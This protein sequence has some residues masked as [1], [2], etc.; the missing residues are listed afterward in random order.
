MRGLT[1]LVGLSLLLVLTGCGQ[2]PS[3]DSSSNPVAGSRATDPALGVTPGA[4]RTHH[5][6]ASL[7]DRGELAVYEPALTRRDGAYT[8]HRAD[9]S[10]EH[11]LHAIAG[12]HLRVSTPAGEQLDIQFDRAIEHPSGDWTWVGHIAGHDDQQTI[13]TFGQDAAFGTIGQPDGQP[14]RLTVQ[15]RASWIVET[16]PTQFAGYRRASPRGHTDVLMVPPKSGGTAGSQAQGVQ[17]Q[18]SAPVMAAATTATTPTTV[19]LVLGYT[20]GFATA[21]GG[22]SGAITHLNY[23][24][25]VANLA[26]ANSQVPAKVRLVATV[27]VNY[28]DATD[29]DSTLEKLTGFSTASNSQIPTDPAFNGLRAARD[30]YGADMVSLVRSFREPENAGCGLAWLIGGGRRPIDQSDGDFAYSV[31]GDG[32][33]AGTGGHT[34]FC[35]DETLAHELGHGMGAAHDVQTAKGDNG[36][37]DDNEYGAFSYSFGYVNSTPVAGG[38]AGFFTI[39]AYGDN[40]TQKI[41]RTFSNPRTTFCGGHPCGTADADNAR[42]LTQT[43]PIIATFRAT[44]VPGGQPRLLLKDLDANGDGKSDLLLRSRSSAWSATWFMSGTSRIGSNGYR[45]GSAYVLAATGDLNGDRR[46]DLVW[47]SPARDVVIW[48]STG[49]GYI[50]TRT[51]YTYDAHTQIVGAAS[52]T[53]N[54]KADILLRDA[55]AGKLYV[56]YM[57]GTTRVTYN[58]HFVDGS[59]ELVGSGDLNH[60][61]KQDLV[62]TSSRRDVLIS[63]S[64]GWNFGTAPEGETYA[65]DYELVG[66]TDVNGNGAADLLFRSTSAGRLAIWFMDGRTRVAASSKPMPLQYR[67]VGKG[68]FNG[69]RRGDLAWTDGSGHIALSLST[70]TNFADSIL[71]YTYASG[72]ALMDAN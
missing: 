50:S 28:P 62:W 56:W 66:V 49:T 9:L 4:G 35:L 34:Y 40:S 12:G 25:D 6:F 46:T 1:R 43:I 37:L 48:M 24:V 71:P 51:P 54:G 59:Y 13:L 58:A 57:D 31:I 68:D 64:T 18:G 72:Y 60:D 55:S 19:D 63:I 44:V 36:V 22:T 53:G 10:E 47:T 33:D 38:S 41:Y 52:I 14:L 39:M 69:D 23:L 5:G 70:G 32:H 16:D 61:G 21:N 30:Q 65:S 8:W 7:P 17:M 20:T 11:A 2:W 3:A 27:A 42:T 29:N 15:D 26:Y 45:L 67:L